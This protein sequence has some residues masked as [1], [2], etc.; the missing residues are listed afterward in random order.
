MLRLFFSFFTLSTFGLDEYSSIDCNM[1][2]GPMAI[3]AI[4]HRF[5]QKRRK[6]K[7]QQGVWLVVERV[8]TWQHRAAAGFY[9]D[10]IYLNLTSVVQRIFSLIC[11]IDGKETPRRRF[12]PSCKNGNCVETLRPKVNLPPLWCLGKWDLHPFA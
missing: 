12:S 7:P 3:H 2:F 9:I 10:A 1:Y 8:T 6:K 5:S 11:L 4:K